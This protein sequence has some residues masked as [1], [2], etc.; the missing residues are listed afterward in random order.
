MRVDP[1]IAE[2]ERESHQIVQL[3]CSEQVPEHEIDRRIARLRD[4]ARS[5]FPDRPEVFEQTYG[6]RF[7]RL[8]TRFHPAPG[9]F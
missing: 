2:L 7:A 1:A 6:Q 4:R 5:V 3:I 9:L 8:R